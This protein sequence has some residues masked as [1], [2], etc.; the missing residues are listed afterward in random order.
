MAWCLR[1]VQ[2]RMLCGALG[3]KQLSPADEDLFLCARQNLLNHF[4]VRHLLILCCDSV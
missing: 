3:M 4:E 2:T 1:C